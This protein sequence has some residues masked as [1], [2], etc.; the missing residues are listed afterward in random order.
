MGLMMG[1]VMGL[2]YG[3]SGTS[4]F[5]RPRGYARI[6]LPP[7]GYQALADSFPYF[8]EYGSTARIEVDSSWMAEPHWIYVHYP[9]YGASIQVT[10][11]A[12]GGDR[13]LLE[14]I[15]HDTYQL[16]AKHQVKAYAM[17]ERILWVPVGSVSYMRITGEV[18]TPVRSEEHTS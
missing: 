14:E 3:C 9:D 5:P 15:L 18:P 2:S 17:Q 13:G 11:K 6:D 12:I 8:F 4:D 16:S 10:Y 1:L 7:H